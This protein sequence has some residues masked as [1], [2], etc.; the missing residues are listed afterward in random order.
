MAIVIPYTAPPAP[1]LTGNPSLYEEFDDACS[2]LVPV[3]IVNT[4]G[5][6]VSM[7]AGGVELAEDPSPAWSSTATYGVQDR[8]YL[9]HRLYE[10]VKPNNINRNPE[11]PSNQVD[12]AGLATWWIDLDEPTNRTAMFDGRIDSQTIAPSPLVITI[13][14]G[15][16]NGFALF[17]VDADSISVQVLDAPNGNVIYEEPTTP[18]EGSMPSDYYEYLFDPFK[19][20]RQLIRTGLEPNGSAQIKLTL[21]RATGNVGVGMLAIG[22]VKP[23][24]IPQ[25]DAV[26]RPQDF[27]SIVRD[28]FGRGRVRRR[29]NATGMTIPCVNQIEDANSIIETIR[30]T[31]GVP[32]VVIG[33]KHPLYAWM[34][35]FGTI[36]AEMRPTPYPYC[37]INLEIQGF[38]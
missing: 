13:S 1:P 9:N 32:C 27:S 12:G 28:K 19:P 21:N 22:D 5:A 10:S 37:T 29:G 14:P 33:S 3:D 31:L 16:F 34:T 35:V 4:P 36:S 23:V 17:G 24:G 8:V 30:N 25:R 6:L 11:L 26:V 38:I 20:L 15:A 18:L 7:T 2:I